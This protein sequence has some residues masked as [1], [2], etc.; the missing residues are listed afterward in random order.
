MN[1]IAVIHATN[2]GIILV[3]SDKF[4]EL[5][6]KRWQIIDGYGRRGISGNKCVYIHREISKA[7]KGEEVDHRT[8]FRWVNTSWNLRV[9][10][11]SQNKWNMRK[12][13]GVSKYKGVSFDS[14]RGKWFAQIKT[15]YKKTWLG[16]YENERDAAIAYNGAALL[17]HGDCALLNEI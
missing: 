6:R 15:H 5:N 14:R 17:Q 16:Y 11:S 2:G 8:H 3:D 12:T 10:T 13:R 7:K 9:G 1:N 4:Q